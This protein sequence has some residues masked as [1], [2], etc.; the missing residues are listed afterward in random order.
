[1]IVLDS[2]AL[3]AVL[4]AEPKAPAIAECM[5]GQ[6]LTMSVAN[7]LECGTVLAG[8]RKDDPMRA[9]RHLDRALTQAGVQLAAVDA[10][11]ARIALEARIRF[12]KG[13]GHPAALNFGDCFAYALAKTLNAPLLYVGDDFKHTDIEAAL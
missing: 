4:F 6:P 10:D 7:Y 5:S 12:G 9:K 8:R 2:S 11:Q 1:M 13:F 3:V